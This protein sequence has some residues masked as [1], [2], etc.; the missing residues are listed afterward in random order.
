MAVALLAAAPA[1]ASSV[2]VPDDFYG[3]NFQRIAAMGPAAQDTHL[4]RIESLGISQVRLNAS[5]AAIEP[6]APVLGVHSYRWD[7]LDQ[8]VAALARHGIRAQPTLTQPPDWDAVQ[9]TWVDLQCSKS[10]SRSPVDTEPYAAFVRAFAARYG[11][12]GAFWTGHPDVPYTPVFRYEIWNEP[13]LKGGWCPHPQPWLYA[14]LFV[15]ATQAIRAVDPAAAV[16]TGGVAPPSGKNAKKR[17]Q[18]MG[19][20]DF[21]GGV[22][23]RQ[24]KITKLMSGANVH[25]YPGLDRDKQLEKLAWFRDQLRRGRIPNGMPMVINEIGWATHV[26]KSPLTEDDRAAAYASMTV[27]YARTNCNV[28]GIVPHSWM[29][30]ERS[31]TNPEDWYGIANPATG[32]PYKSAQRYSYGLRLMRGELSKEPPMRTLMAC[33]GMPLPDSDRDGFPDQ[34]DYYPLNPD[35]H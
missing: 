34:S 20:A 9:G 7:A 19:I 27:N 6:H 25:V 14:D 2:R 11:R 5:W 8:R 1:Q 12:G 15:K 3:I 16:F 4:S 10:A 24:P 28:G 32:K 26:G 18:Y 21:F 13:N 31:K 29:S 30:P 23:A 35:R 22:T 33:E 17:K